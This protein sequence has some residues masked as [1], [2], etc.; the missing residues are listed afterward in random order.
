M[1]N[2]LFNAHTT[3]RICNTTIS[4]TNYQIVLATNMNVPK[5]RTKF[6][7]PKFSPLNFTWSLTFFI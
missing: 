3:K 2:A 4:A 1:S 7:H 5:N 6:T